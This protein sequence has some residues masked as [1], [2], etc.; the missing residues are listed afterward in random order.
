MGAQVI[1]VCLSNIAVVTSFCF[2]HCYDT[3][4]LAFER[5]YDGSKTLQLFV[6][7]ERAKEVAKMSDTD[8]VSE[9]LPII[10]DMFKEQIMNKYG[11][12]YE[13]KPKDVVNFKAARW[14]EDPLFYGSFSNSK[15]NQ[16]DA[17]L[18]LLYNGAG[19]IFMVR[20]SWILQVPS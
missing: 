11:T 14:S 4:N 7:G 9:F 10:N 17:Q 18:E 8:I 5:I 3:K 19:N 1:L 6:T 20:D 15:F 13:L 12:S 2:C 16:T